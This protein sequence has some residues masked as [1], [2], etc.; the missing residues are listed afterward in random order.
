MV[1]HF[2]ITSQ[3]EKGTLPVSRFTQTC[4]WVSPVGYSS[5][6]PLATGVPIYHPKSEPDEAVY[7]LKVIGTYRQLLALTNCCAF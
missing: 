5:E 3:V 1:C 7:F 6:T 4:V 2:I